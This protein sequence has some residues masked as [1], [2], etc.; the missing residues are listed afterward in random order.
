M[1]IYTCTYA[2][3]YY[4]YLAHFAIQRTDPGHHVRQHL[5]ALDALR[6]LHRGVPLEPARGMGAETAHALSF[7][8]DRWRATPGYTG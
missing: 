1:C 2:Y 5:E 8:A 7:R 4:A 6:S 3:I